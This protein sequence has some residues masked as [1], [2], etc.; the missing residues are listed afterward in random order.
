MKQKVLISGFG[1]QGIM[2]IGN[3]FAQ[4]AFESGLETTVMPTYGVEQ[5]G[6]T[7]NTTVTISDFPIGSPTAPHPDVLV[8]MNQASIDRFGPAIRTNG[9]MIV[10]KSQMERPFSRNDITV[11]GV[12]ADAIAQEIGSMKTA[13]VVIL[14]TLVGCLN[15]LLPYETAE[16]VMIKKLS[17]KPE[18]AEMNKRAFRRGFEV[19]SAF[20]KRS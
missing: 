1:G 4:A 9:Q 5:R 13:N 18:F 15:G 11:I 8:A 12:D 19:G 20:L 3:I 6:G 17:K 10:N 16:N 2:M 7:A 14:G